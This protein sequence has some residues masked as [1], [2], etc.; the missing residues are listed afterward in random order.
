MN[1]TDTDRIVLRVLSGDI[2]AY[3]EI[4]HR[5]QNEVWKV[6]AAL[7]LDNQK[8]EDL[9]Q[10]AFVNA[11]QHLH[12]YE[13][14]RDFGPWIR[15]IARNVARQEIRRRLREDRRMELYYNHWLALRDCGGEEHDVQLTEALRRCEE[16]LPPEAVRLVELRY[17]AAQ[18]FGEIAAALGRT[19]EATRQHL[20]RIRVALRDCIQKQLA[21]L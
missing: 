5:Y 21:Q 7:L 18:S 6:V 16:K 15:E 12:R 14:G 13:P 17:R 4:V 2:D 19:V 10:Q 8:T 9:V 3:A 20:A 11:Y 1:P